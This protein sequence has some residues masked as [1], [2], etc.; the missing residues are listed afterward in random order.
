[1]SRRYSRALQT[2]RRQRQLHSALRRPFMAAAPVAAPPSAPSDDDSDDDQ[3]FVASRSRWALPPPPPPPAAD[4]DGQSLR[5]CRIASLV[6][7]GA[8]ELARIEGCAPAGVSISARALSAEAAR[9]LRTRNQPISDD[10]AVVAAAAAEIDDVLSGADVWFGAFWD[11]VP[12]SMLLGG[13]RFPAALRWLCVSQAGA[14]QVGKYL[15]EEGR[16]LTMG[17]SD[18]PLVTNCSGMNS[19]WIG[20][21]VIGFMTA[22]CMGLP[23]FLEQQKACSWTKQP[24]GS[25]RVRAAAVHRKPS[26]PDPPPLP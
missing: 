2:L 6:P 4:S 8:D 20:E 19:S 24:S 13:T 10:P 16:S 12:G 7:L 11:R 9:A 26:C 1:M 22:H 18:S 5:V 14:S 17:D 23:R 21:W 25:I 15:S 3:V